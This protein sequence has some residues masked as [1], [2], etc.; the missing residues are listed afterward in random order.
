M[1]RISKLFPTE[2]FVINKKIP[3]INTR[4]R[5]YVRENKKETQ[6]LWQDQQK[7]KQSQ[8][9]MKL[10]WEGQENLSDRISSLSDGSC[11]VVMMGFYMFC[12]L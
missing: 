7:E 3:R 11:V 4:F 12:V 9:E 10:L 8:Q 2:S 5:M 6:H 1:R